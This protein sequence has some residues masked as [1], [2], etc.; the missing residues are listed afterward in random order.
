MPHI[1]IDHS[2]NLDTG[3]DLQ[4]LSDELARVAVS[5]GV[6]PKGGIR[7]RFHPARVWTIADGHPDNA[8]VAALLRI[9]EGRD[10]ETRGRAAKAIH[11]ALCAFFAK[12]LEGGHFMVSTDLQVNEAAV[13]FKTNTVHAR[14]AGENAT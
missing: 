8:Y 10:T 3:H 1:V 11:D 13:S 2:D 5:T 6:F 14:L 4:A 12:E 7:V 9:G